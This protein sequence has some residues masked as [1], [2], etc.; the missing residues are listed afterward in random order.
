MNRQCLCY[1]RLREMNERN[2]IS[3]LDIFA[4]RLSKTVLEHLSWILT[5]PGV[6]VETKIFPEKF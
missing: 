1:G 2:E 3:N 4:N 5:L 6:Q